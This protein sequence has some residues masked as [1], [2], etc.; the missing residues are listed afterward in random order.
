MYTRTD[1]TREPSWPTGARHLPAT[2]P[3]APVPH[4][5]G[6]HGES[7]RRGVSSQNNGQ[8]QRRHRVSF[9]ETATMASTTKPCG[10]CGAAKEKQAFS[11]KQ[12]NAK[13]IRRCKHCVESGNALADGGG[14]AAVATTANISSASGIYIPRSGPVLV[15]GSGG[16]ASAPASAASAA[17]QPPTTAPTPIEGL[18]FSCVSCGTAFQP[19]DYPPSDRPGLVPRC[20]ACDHEAPFYRTVRVSGRNAH[21]LVAVLALKVVAKFIPPEELAKLSAL[22]G[23]VLSPDRPMYVTLFGR[24]TVAVGPHNHPPTPTG[25]STRA[26]WRRRLALRQRRIRGRTSRRARTRA[27]PF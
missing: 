10:A 1:A 14:P 17:F 23:V 5:E 3:A 12:W 15:T 2:P 19:S 18:K 9:A 8:N 11:S 27:S 24:Q 20:S 21:P 7:F 16:A 4:Q 13:K 22:D 26:W 25:S 6:G